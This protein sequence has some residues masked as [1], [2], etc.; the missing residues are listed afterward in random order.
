[1][2]ECL[3]MVAFQ[4]IGNDHVVSMAQQAGQLELNVMAP[5][6]V[7]NILQSCDL[8]TNFL[9]AFVEKCL[10]GLTADKDQCHWYFY[11][12]TSL[13]TLLNTT[14]GYMSAAE[15]VKESVKTGKP[16]A[17]LVVE[18]GLLTKEQVTDLLQ[19]KRVTGYLDS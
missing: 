11:H 4:V 18:K 14:I 12:S 2:P 8:L 10:A 1:M 17:E 19:P 13:A 5:V 9:P 7:H 6:M 16:F 3:N 15:L